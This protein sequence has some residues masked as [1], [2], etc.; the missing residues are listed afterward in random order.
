MTKNKW[1]KKFKKM[2]LILILVLM[3]STSLVFAEYPQNGALPE[4]RISTQYFRE[5]DFSNIDNYKR[6]D[7]R[8]KMQPI[9]DQGRNNSC[10]A[11]AV[12]GSIEYQFKT[13]IRKEIKFSK[14]YNWYLARK[15]I[16]RENE[17]AGVLIYSSIQSTINHGLLEQKYYPESTHYAEE[18]TFNN[19]YKSIKTKSDIN[20]VVYD[21]P[22]IMMYLQNDIPVIFNTNTKVWE[23]I[24][25]V[26]D[27]EGIIRN[28][29]NWDKPIKPNSG[30]AML[31]VGYIPDFNIDGERY[32]V[33]I[34][35]NSW[36]TRYG[37]RGYHYIPVENLLRYNN[38]SLNVVR[39]DDMELNQAEFKEDLFVKKTIYTDNET[40]DGTIWLE[41]NRYGYLYFTNS[42]YMGG[43]DYKRSA[44]GYML[45]LSIRGFS[46]EAMKHKKELEEKSKR[47][48]QKE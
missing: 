9:Y 16:N 3:L 6:V 47:L 11:Q 18:P 34:I 5:F 8:D 21:F 23:G 32:P 14:V 45:P 46:V 39:V 33:F 22:E 43:G 12:I 26:F 28:A 30:H 42:K 10:V 35:R 27:D 37:D 29:L 7:L 38:N 40:D 24:N 41:N 44:E 25:N 36:G 17:N 19:L 20:L 15:A 31:I 2:T 48:Y 1:R 13:R 4:S